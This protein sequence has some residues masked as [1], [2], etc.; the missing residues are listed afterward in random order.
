[1][2]AAIDGGRRTVVV[3]DDEPI[4]RMDLGQMLEGLGYMVAGYAGDGFDAVELCRECRPD[5]VVMDIKMPTFDGLTAAEEIIRDHLARCV[6]ILS[7]FSTPAFIE[8]AAGIGVLGYLVKPVEEQRLLPVLEIALSQ[9]GRL[10]KAAAAAAALQKKLDAAKVVGQAK[11]YLAGQ[12][13]ISE[14]EAYRR[15]QRM[16]MDKRCTVE[17]LAGVL[18][19]RY[20]SRGVVDQA[21]E[22]LM[23]TKGISES[24][25]FRLIRARAGEAGVE[26]AEAARLIL[27]QGEQD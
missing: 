24:Q 17:E 27:S 10:E 7:A 2:D 15:L 3:A 5:V 8:R 18:V 1:M 11:A 14:G 25:A 26:L 4:T 21:K 6:I 9:A 19:N 12:E 23:R 20:S 13:E 16:A 22:K